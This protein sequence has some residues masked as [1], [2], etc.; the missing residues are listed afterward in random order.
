MVSLSHAHLAEMSH[1][2]R[3]QCWMLIHPRP[4]Q[5]TAFALSSTSCLAQSNGSQPTLYPFSTR[6]S[7]LGSSTAVSSL[8][9][10]ELIAFAWLHTRAAMQKKVKTYN[11]L[12]PFFCFPYAKMFLVLCWLA[13]HSLMRAGSNGCLPRPGIPSACA[14]LSPHRL[15]LHS[16]WDSWTP[17]GRAPPTALQNGAGEPQANAATQCHGQSHGY[18]QAQLEKN[19]TEE[20]LSMFP[21]SQGLPSPVPNGQG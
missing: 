6:R 1:G 18:T 4:L 15:G 20:A 19:E 9:L 11:I 7:M 5:V 10:R 12:S 2:L 8:G 17:T 13:F 3:P 21:L 14:D 16:P